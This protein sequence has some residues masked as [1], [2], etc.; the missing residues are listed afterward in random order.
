MKSSAAPGALLAVL[1]LSALAAACAPA[2]PPAPQPASMADG[3]KCFGD[4]DYACA[5][6]NYR[7]Y[8][9]LY[10][11]DVRANAVLGITLTRESKHHDALPYFQKAIDA[12]EGTYDL[13]ANYALSLDATGDTEGAIKY[14]R[15]ALDAVPSL[16][17]V[18][19]A[20]AR[21]LAKQ[22]KTD[23]AIKLLRDF[24][25]HLVSLGEQPYFTGQIAALEDKAAKK[26]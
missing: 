25:K 9:K 4:R 1:A 23:E 26:P 15:R 7:G 13:Y 21:Q 3:D 12:G 17:D 20:L 5:E 2:T 8:L 22:G 16:V 10:P 6:A 24:D 14:N 19:G 11:Q 18:R